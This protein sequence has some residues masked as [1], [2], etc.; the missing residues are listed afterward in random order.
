MSVLFAVLALAVPAA[1]PG[2]TTDAKLIC[3]KE[4]VTGSR[5]G[6][7]RICKTAEEWAE[8]RRLDRETVERLQANRYKGNE[9]LTGGIQGD[10]GRNR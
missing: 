5:L 8:T 4:A 9:G 7:K 2:T 1:A 3:A 6:A 10:F